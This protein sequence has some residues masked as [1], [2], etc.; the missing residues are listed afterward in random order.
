[1]IQE[2]ENHLEVNISPLNW[3][4]ASLRLCSDGLLVCTGCTMA[5][6]I[7]SARRHCVMVRGI[8]LKTDEAFEK[9]DQGK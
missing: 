3:I 4:V 8:M 2:K 9:A 7:A 1:M 5:D 6:M